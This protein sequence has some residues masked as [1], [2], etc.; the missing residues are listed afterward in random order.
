M[1]EQTGPNDRTGCCLPPSVQRSRS[2][3]EDDADSLCNHRKMG[4]G[5]IGVTVGK[6]NPPHLGHQHLVTAA[7]ERVDELHVLLCDRP[8]QSLSATDRAA[9]LRDAVPAN[10]VIHVTP[11]DL[12]E[13]NEPWA[14][15]TLDVL[16][17]R[18]DVAFTSEAYGEGWAEMMGAQHELIDLNRNAFPISATTIRMDAGANFG[19][20]VP[21]AR[22]DL[23]RRVVV[24]GAESTGKSTVAEAMAREMQTAWVP[25]HGRWYWEGRRY[26]ADQR[27]TTDE[28]EA[29]ARSQESLI[30]D[31]ARLSTNG[32]VIAD[33]DALVTCV[34]HERYVGKPLLDVVEPVVPDIYLVCAPDFDW[35]QD[36]TRESAEMR[37]WMHER[38]LEL[39]ERSGAPYAVLEGPAD[40]RL[41]R[42][43]QLV[44]PLTRF[45]EL[46]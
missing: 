12:P 40:E 41:A 26:R 1:K 7:A 23:A 22:A 25:E 2:H 16:P 19:W 4:G 20:L 18:P 28:F 43:L 35:V 37:Q 9:W 42:A 24:A 39:V 32:V 17:S 44:D 13:E 46:I 15:R 8:D 5:K 34:W 29:I 45:P 10:V 36:G 31:L 14:A 33:T 3:T 11:D 27:W 6:F 30:N 21:A 38:T